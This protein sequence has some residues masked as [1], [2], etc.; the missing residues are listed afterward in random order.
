[1][2]LNFRPYSTRAPSRFD[3]QKL[4]KQPS[5]NTSPTERFGYI[6][7][8]TVIDQET[9]TT[10]TPFVC[11]L[12]SRDIRCRR[13]QNF[14]TT[15]IPEAITTTTIPFRE[16]TTL[17]DT[18]TYPNYIQPNTIKP[19]F[20]SFC[21]R[22]PN[23][24][25]CSQRVTGDLGP[26]VEIL[27]F[28]PPSPFATV[29]YQT[30]TDVPTTLPTTTYTPYLSVNCARN[31]KDYRCKQNEI[32]QT[33]TDA[34]QVDEQPLNCRGHNLDPRCPNPTPTNT[35]P[36]YL[37]PSTTQKLISPK[38]EVSTSSTTK[39][40]TITRQPITRQPTTRQPVTKQSITKK[41]T[42]KFFICVPGSNDVNCD[43][44]EKKDE[45]EPS[46]KEQSPEEK[47]PAIPSRSQYTT[48]KPNEKLICS[49]G[50]TN[51][52]CQK[53]ST[54][55]ITSEPKLSTAKPPQAFTTRTSSPR[56]SPCYPG[57]LD[58]K[59]TKLTTKKPVF[60]P[61]S[62]TTNRY[63]AS[64]IPVFVI[65]EQPNCYPG[66]P[67]PACSTGP[68][69]KKTIPK[70]TSSRTTARPTISTTQKM[71][72]KVPSTTRTPVCQPGSSDKRCLELIT[73]NRASPTTSVTQES[74]SE[75]SS[76]TTF[77]PISTFK[78]QCY[79]GS[80][81]P[82]CANL[83]T[84]TE[85]NAEITFTT[86]SIPETT[87]YK[88]TDKFTK[89]PAVRCYP[90][91]LDPQCKQNTKK[92]TF[93]PFKTESR[94]T[95]KLPIITSNVTP[96]VKQTKPTTPR[97]NFTTKG[98][99]T[100][101]APRCYPGS[102]D[103]QCRQ[104]TKKPLAAIPEVSPAFSIITNVQPTR[105]PVCY[106]G[107]L[108]PRCRSTTTTTTTVRSKT[109]LGSRQELI[110]TKPISTTKATPQ[111]YPGSLE[112]RC[113][114]STTTT[115]QRTSIKPI[116]KELIK[117]PV[118]TTLKP[119]FSFS[120][121]PQCYPG[122]ID[123]RC[124]QTTTTTTATTD[125][126]LIEKETFKPVF[127]QKPL[128][129]YPGSLNPKCR[130]TTTTTTTESTPSVSIDLRQDINEVESSSTQ[131]PLQCFPG[132]FDPKCR[133]S[134]TTTTA[135]PTPAFSARQEISKTPT[136]T[137]L[138]PISGINT[139]APK[140]YLGSLDPRCRQL[141]TTSTQ[142]ISSTTLISKIATTTPSVPKLSPTC[143]PG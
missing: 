139:A 98:T 50:S 88:S 123:P 71:I 120:K 29:K 15:Q 77:E 6:S 70:I 115:T 91:S 53:V 73:T 9:T 3:K 126:T 22:Y 94:V 57:S 105:P 78:P 99:S 86:T 54:N 12:G 28:R 14:E 66:S 60:K 52:E 19:A 96:T 135:R 92:P 16:T 39:K 35:P 13:P 59:C 2:P 143:Y 48:R 62:T 109:S 114:Q 5:F 138:K 49:V 75:I 40:P 26:N 27:T 82:R 100:T 97:E 87:T 58:P 43:Y 106:P 68:S 8:T 11:G 61:L 80:K 140:C 110:S 119:A 136:T 132:S 17:R 24:K 47:V 128:Q 83:A 104:T 84:T 81:D 95:T 76:T 42:N 65:Q 38:V 142:R 1:M 36:T 101:A 130:Q 44:E 46:I 51:P 45:Q 55:I 103:P 89:L 63:V 7:T 41:P 69:T 116:E 37:P 141:P 72:Y 18:T 102:F 122:S 137:T 30:T 125:R 113:R 10:Q 108:D 121:S 56:I 107:A 133:Q 111:C 32:I 31:P 21:D 67:D 4:T 93:T 118:S 117:S 23:S 90:G 64:E 129:C 74:T 127:S 112:P 134:F 85:T 33:T 79:F 131:K 34:S 25:R 20:D 124:R